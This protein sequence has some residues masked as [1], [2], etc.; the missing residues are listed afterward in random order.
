MLVCRFC[1]G[2]INWRNYRGAGKKKQ[3]RIVEEFSRRRFLETNDTRFAEIPRGSDKE[4][5]ALGYAADWAERSRVYRRTAGW[6]CED[7]AVEC[8]ARPGLL[9]THHQNGVPS[10][11]RVSNLRALCKLCHAKKHPNWYRVAHEDRSALEAL[12]RAQGL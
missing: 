11:N 1:L 7:C 2:H 4:A 9:D 8:S 3:T 5:P 6:R 10:D 12:R